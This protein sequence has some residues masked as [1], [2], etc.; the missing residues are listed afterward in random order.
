VA[1][2]RLSSRLQSRGGGSLALPSLVPKKLSDRLFVAFRLLCG[3][4]RTGAFFK[5]R[6]LVLLRDAVFHPGRNRSCVLAAERMA[7]M[8]P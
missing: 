4:S 2:Q 6:T 8:I 7:M 3:T 5:K 1:I